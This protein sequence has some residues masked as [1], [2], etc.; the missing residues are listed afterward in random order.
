[1]NEIKVKLE[2]I[3]SEI[4]IFNNRMLLIEDYEKNSF[5]IDGHK[6]TQTLLEKVRSQSVF[7]SEENFEILRREIKSFI[8]GYENIFKE[9]E[10]GMEFNQLMDKLYR[11]IS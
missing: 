11:V 7:E 6:S 4:E 3:I 8:R 10:I 5:V 2:K 9:I 1:M